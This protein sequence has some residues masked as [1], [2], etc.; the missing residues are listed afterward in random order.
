MC[1]RHGGVSD[2][3]ERGKTM[4]S[5]IELIGCRTTR[6]RNARGEGLTS[7][8][9][10]DCGGRR[11]LDLLAMTNPSW[12]TLAPATRVAYVVEGD[13][14]TVSAVRVENDGRLVLL[15]TRDTRGRNPVHSAITGD[16]RLVTTWSVGSQPRRGPDPDTR[17]SHRGTPACCTSSA[18]WTAPC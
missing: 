3:G 4:A 10:D 6:E 1:G 17:P 8:A 12:V 14:G 16:R 5:F 11:R 9:V 18:S 13:G 2:S 15:G 7:W